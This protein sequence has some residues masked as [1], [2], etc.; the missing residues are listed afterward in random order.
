MTQCRPS[1]NFSETFVRHS[2]LR[3]ARAAQG[4]DVAERGGGVGRA[5]GAR[6]RAIRGDRLRAGCMVPAAAS[7]SR[8][9]ARGGGRPQRPLHR[10]HQV[11]GRWRRTPLLHRL[12][13]GAHSCTVPLKRIAPCLCGQKRRAIIARDCRRAP[14]IWLCFGIVASC[15][16]GGLFRLHVEDNLST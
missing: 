9:R 8:R 3:R 10:F 12:L 15:L 4:S 7:R 14:S 2:C 13:Q 16:S 11:V 1:E 5:V 6:L